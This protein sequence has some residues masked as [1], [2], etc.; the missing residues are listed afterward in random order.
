MKDRWVAADQIQI[1]CQ[2]TDSKLKHIS[3]MMIRPGDYIN[4]TVVLDISTFRGR[5][6]RETRINFAMMRIVQPSAVHQQP[7]VQDSAQYSTVY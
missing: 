6:G 3:H 7:Q 1:G 2:D 5:D 4:V